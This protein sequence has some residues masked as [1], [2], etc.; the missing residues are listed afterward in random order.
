[1]L[2]IFKEVGDQTTKQVLEIEKIMYRRTR[3]EKV[4][5]YIK[6]CLGFKEN[7]YDKEEEFLLALEEL[8]LREKELDISG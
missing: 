8:D 7:D 6:N 1:M 4:E 5:E 2:T 3:M